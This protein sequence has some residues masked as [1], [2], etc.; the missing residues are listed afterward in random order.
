MA[1]LVA[2]CPR[3]GAK[4]HTFVVNAFNHIGNNDWQRCFEAS[5]VC[6]HCKKST[7][8]Y[9]NQKRAGDRDLFYNMSNLLIYPESLNHIMVI[10]GFVNIRNQKSISPPEYTPEN[11]AK[12]FLEGAESVV[13]NCPN[14][15]AAMFRLCIDLVTKSLLPDSD[16]YDGLNKSV[17]ERLYNRLDW[18]FKTNRLP[19]DLRELSN[20]IRE[21]G[22]DGAHD[23]T[24]D[25]TDAEDLLD[26]CSS[27]LE[28]VYTEPKKIKARE[29]KRLERRNKG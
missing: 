5:S 14:A 2:D 12:I 29:Q 19:E 6:R 25:K 18:L 27:L 21:D 9:L 7:I 4:N 13:G 20:C 28:R 3:C 8:F 22:N 10:E 26:F 15:A 11:I 24:L 16:E 17:R 1:E 23:G